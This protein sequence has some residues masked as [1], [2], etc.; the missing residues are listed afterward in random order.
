MIKPLVRQVPALLD[1]ARYPFRHVITTRYADVDP[2]DHINNVALA[3][4]LED[5]RARFNRSFDAGAMGAGLRFMIVA[6]YI[7][8]VGEAH[9]P[10]P[11]EMYAGVMEIGRSSWAVGCLAA[12][13]GRA[14]AFGRG[15]MVGTV[16][17]RAVPVPE[18]VR[19]QFAANCIDLP[20]GSI[21][22]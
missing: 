11:L 14:C 5:V 16:D 9:Y 4:A 6:N 22:A 10:D 7:D 1:Y 17:G 20:P 3:A 13:N 15:V 21:P 2:N 8:Y 19:A 18:G 12:Q